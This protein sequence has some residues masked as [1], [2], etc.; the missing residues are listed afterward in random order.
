MTHPRKKFKLTHYREF[1]PFA[2]KRNRNPMIEA[3]VESHPSKE[4]RVGHPGFETGTLKRN[5]G[6]H[7]Y[8]LTGS[9]LK[10]G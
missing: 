6:L 7:H 9:L 4:R 8:Y 5:W 3:S 1:P 10:K 2:K